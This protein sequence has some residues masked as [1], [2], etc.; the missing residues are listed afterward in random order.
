MGSSADAEGSA[1]GLAPTLLGG[2]G[3]CREC[4]KSSGSLGDDLHELLLVRRK[5]GV[6]LGRH[7]DC[8]VSESVSVCDAVKTR[9][10]TIISI[11]RRN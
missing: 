10:E 8:A 5:S 9:M 4:C 6:G 7:V 2:G 11:L 1:L 3:G